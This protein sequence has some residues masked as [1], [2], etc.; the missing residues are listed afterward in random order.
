MRIMIKFNCHKWLRL[1]PN[2]VLDL[3]L[4]GLFMN[5]DK[6]NQTFTNLK[7]YV[8]NYIK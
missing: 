8:R 7:R 6:N 3:D 1:D 2:R 5:H 4:F